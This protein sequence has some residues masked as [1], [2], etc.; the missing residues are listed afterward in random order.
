M[1]VALLV[2][3][4]QGRPVPCPGPIDQNHLDPVHDGS[5]PP[6][7]HHHIAKTRCI[8]SGCRDAD[9]GQ[10]EQ[11]RNAV[12][13]LLGPTGDDRPVAELDRRTVRTCDPRLGVRGVSS[14]QLQETR[15][16]SICRNNHRQQDAHHGHEDPSRP[17]AG[18]HGSLPRPRRKHLLGYPMEFH[19]D[20]LRYLSEPKN[21]GIPEGRPPLK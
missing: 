17:S 1:G 10:V 19:L 16:L 5:L 13:G 20:E 11:V 14:T 7:R 21:G 15:E 8:L 3:R 12:E 6:R 9:V 2:G 18:P 4:T